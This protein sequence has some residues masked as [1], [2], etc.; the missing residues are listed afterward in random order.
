MYTIEEVQMVIQN[1]P[2]SLCVA[3]IIV[4]VAG[5]IEYF[6][7]MALQIR[8]HKSPFGFWQH[9][10]FFGHDLTFVLLFSLWFKVV[11]YWIFKVMWAGCIG[12]VCIEFI[13]LYLTIKYDR[14]EVFGK[15]TNGE[16]T[17]KRAWIRGLSGYALGWVLFYLLHIGIGD[18]ML[19]ALMMSTEVVAAIGP[20][21]TMEMRGSRYGASWV[22]GVVVVIMTII[23]FAPQGIGLWAT[24]A[25]VFRQPWY[26][27]LGAVSIICAVRYLLVMKKLPKKT[28]LPNGKKPIF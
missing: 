26:Y 12:F 21:F 3:V 25:E 1:D 24:V 8:E 7:S 17:V 5:F 19:F 6:Y 20:A 14:Q 11:D 28:L 13:S 27:C 15:F 23:T 16:I 2:V 10:W 4:W 18:P 9:A 22:W